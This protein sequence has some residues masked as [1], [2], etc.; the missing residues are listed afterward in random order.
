MRRL[1]ESF[2]HVGSACWG[3]KGG[4]WPADHIFSVESE[5]DFDCEGLFLAIGH[6]PNTAIFEG[7][8]N[9][10][11]TGYIITDGVKTNVEGVWA[12]GDVQGWVGALE[13][14]NLGGMAAAMIVHGWYEAGAAA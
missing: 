9:L 2:L 14:A 8:I 13:S 4:Q 5:S 12:A 3:E 7:Q 11:E 6:R 10:D 1:L